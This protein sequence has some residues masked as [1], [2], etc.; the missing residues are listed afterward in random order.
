MYPKPPPR[1]NYVVDR[2][3]TLQEWKEQNEIKVAELARRKG[4]RQGRLLILVMRMA[5]TRR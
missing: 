4:F 3:H 2:A 5:Q 1:G